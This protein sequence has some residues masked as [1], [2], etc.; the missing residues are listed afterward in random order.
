MSPVMRG[1]FSW[2][3]IDAG[4]RY[5]MAKSNTGSIKTLLMRLC[6]VVLWLNQWFSARKLRLSIFII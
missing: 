1:P 3:L 5:P 2:L 6:M 4:N